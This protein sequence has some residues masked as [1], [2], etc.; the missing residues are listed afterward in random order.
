M[1][2]FAK[3]LKQNALLLCAGALAFGFLY[4]QLADF[5]LDV[6]SRLTR[7]ETLISQ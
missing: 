4:V 6:T 5:K 3:A 7:L 2:A 1:E